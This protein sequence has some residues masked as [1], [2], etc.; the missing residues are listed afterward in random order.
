[1]SKAFANS[2]NTTFAELASRMSPNRLTGGRLPV[3]HRAGLHVKRR[4]ATVT[5]SRCPRP[6]TWPNSPRTVRQGKVLASLFGMALAAATVAAGD[7]DP[8]ADRR[9]RDTETGDARRSTRPMLD[10]LR[11]M[12]RMVVTNGTARDINGRAGLR[13]DR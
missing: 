2:C 3:R 11:A 13:Q 10:G 5:G 8:A 4:P 7:P 9:H 6:S 1:M 12:M